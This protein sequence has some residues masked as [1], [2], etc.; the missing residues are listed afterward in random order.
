MMA[1][2]AEVLD[3][4][5]ALY[6]ARRTYHYLLSAGRFDQLDALRQQISE[7]A[8]RLAAACGPAHPAEEDRRD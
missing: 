6:R 3:S 5:D 2:T 1:R 4:L 7:L 8:S